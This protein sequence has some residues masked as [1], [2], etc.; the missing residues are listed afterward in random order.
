MFLIVWY[1]VT[2]L[3]PVTKLSLTGPRSDFGA[4]PAS[5]RAEDSLGLT[6][7]RQLGPQT[8]ARDPGQ[9]TDGTAPGLEAVGQRMVECLEK[10]RSTEIYCTVCSIRIIS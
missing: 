3:C 6:G 7:P 10:C 2:L 9:G 5:Q 8:V 4:L 1:Y